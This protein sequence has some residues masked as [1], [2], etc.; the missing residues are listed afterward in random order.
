MHY[1]INLKKIYKKTHCKFIKKGFRNK[2]QAILTTILVFFLLVILFL[3]IILDNSTSYINKNI[4]VINKIDDMLSLSVSTEEREGTQDIKEINDNMKS[5]NSVSAEKNNDSMIDENNVNQN[6][7]PQSSIQSIPI[8]EEPSIT[9]EVPNG[10]KTEIEVLDYINNL[11]TSV[12]VQ[13]L[14]WDN[15]IYSFAKIRAN[16]ISNLY[17][18]VRPD[19][20]TSASSEISIRAENLAYGQVSASEIFEDWKNSPS[21]YNNLV[22]STYTKGTIAFFIKDEVYYWVFLAS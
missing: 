16:E 18:H 2:I 10:T 1:R 9:I 15:S 11:R 12:G 4:I 6:Q 19:G 20:T 5:Y 22:D 21:H 3:L 17:S 8:L 7:L 14:I 13:K